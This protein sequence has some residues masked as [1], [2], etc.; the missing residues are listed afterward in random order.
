MRMFLFLFSAITLLAA[1]GCTR[2]LPVSPLVVKTLKEEVSVKL[3]PHHE[4]CKR[5]R[6]LI[7]DFDLQY[8]ANDPVLEAWIASMIGG[9][10]YLNTCG[11]FFMPGEE[12]E[13]CRIPEPETVPEAMARIQFAGMAE[14]R[15]ELAE[16]DEF[17][18]QV[19]CRGE[20]L[21]SELDGYKKYFAYCTE[22]RLTEHDLRYCSYYSLISYALSGAT[23]GRQ[24]R[25]V[26]D[27]TLGRR[28][29]IED[30]IHGKRLED[31]RSFFYTYLRTGDPDQANRARK[32]KQ[33]VIP[34]EVEAFIDRP[35]AARRNK[36]NTLDNFNFMPDGIFWTELV[37]GGWF[38]ERLFP[39]EVLR[40]YLRDP[41][42]EKRFRTPKKQP[43]RQK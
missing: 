43:L 36:R 21:E 3:P 42:L 13:K 27:R 35:E 41:S 4:G 12:L 31:F 33:I 14:H 34:E 19:P 30:L 29:T 20:C 24:I 2:K 25:G 7:L 26:F 8:P 39:W 15:K 1:G 6:I 16:G 17:D 10:D 9:A 40:P 5:C 11:T 37:D 28:M 22:T 23:Y 38:C 32:K 18:Y